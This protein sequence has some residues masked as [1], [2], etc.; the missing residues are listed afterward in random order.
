MKEK[1]SAKPRKQM[2]L[3]PDEIRLLEALRDPK[4]RDAI[5]AVLKDMR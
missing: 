3:T 2:V 4:R 5:I 1:E